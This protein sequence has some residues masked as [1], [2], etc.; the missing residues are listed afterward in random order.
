MPN[1]LSERIAALRKER[2]LTQEQLGRLVGVSYQAVGKWE[3]GGAPDVEL[4]PVLSRQLGVTID[5]LFGMEGGAQEDPADAVGRWL[6]G[7]PSKERLDQF[8]RLVW[9]SKKYFIPDEE[10]EISLPVTDYPETCKFAY[11]DGSELLQL[12]QIVTEG[13]ILFDV[14]AE[15]LSFATL[16]SKPKGGWAQWLAPKEEYRKLFSVLARPGCL[17]LMEYIYNRKIGWFS[18]SV[19][20]KHLNMAREAVEEL[21]EALTELKLVSSMELELEEGETKVYEVTEPWKLIPFLVLARTLM[22]CESNYL[23]LYCAVPLFGPDEIWEDAKKGCAGQTAAKI[24][25]E[26]K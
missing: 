13:G 1:L 3:K 26:T 18:T 10:G 16:W 8:C 19:V 22:Q 2:G 25:P 23:R 17:E 6:R 24:S 9:A 20:T 14:H 11:G 7:F 5:A 21:L 4:L 15:D 12:S